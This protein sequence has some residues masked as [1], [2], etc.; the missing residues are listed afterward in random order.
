MKLVI[1]AKILQFYKKRFALCKILSPT[2]LA[3]SPDERQQ[4]K[5]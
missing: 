4:I 2:P 5:C 3:S 1:I